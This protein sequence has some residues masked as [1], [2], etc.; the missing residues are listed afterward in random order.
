MGRTKKKN[1]VWH[2]RLAHVRDY[3]VARLARYKLAV[4]ISN[5]N[6][7][8]PTRRGVILLAG[9]LFLCAAGVR[10]A[11]Y[12]AH[13]HSELLTLPILD[14]A[15]YLTWA[16]EIL[17]GIPR[18]LGAFFTEPG[19]AYLMA[20]SLHLFQTWTP[21]IWVQL[22]L[23]STLPVLTFFT[24]R[25]LFANTIVAF[26]AGLLM[27]FFRPG[28]FHDILLLKTSFEL[29]LIATLV[30]WIVY[31]WEKRVWWH[32]LITGLLVGLTALIK[33]NVL[34][35][36]P[37]FALAL[38]FPR[39]DTMRRAAYATLSMC[40]GAVLAISPTTIHNIRTTGEI[41][42]I[43]YSGGVTVYIG[44]WEH[45][46]GSFMVPEYFSL[47]PIH[48]EVSWHA[49]AEALSGESLTASETSSYWLHAGIR[50]A[51]AFPGHFIGVTLK[52][53][54]LLFSGLEIAD[55]YAVSFG[56]M[57]FPL[58]V[59]LVPYWLITLLGIVGLVWYVRREGKHHSY[60]YA[61]LAGYAGLVIISKVAERYRM[62]LAVVLVLFAAYAL[63][64]LVLL[65]KK[66][67][68][69]LEFTF[70]VLL[71][72]LASGV[73][74][75]VHP[76]VVTTEPADMYL[77]FAGAYRDA[78]EFSKALSML[79]AGIALSPLHEP[80][81][82]NKGHI[83][84]LSGDAPGALHMYRTALRAR[85]DGSTR[86]LSLSYPCVTEGCDLTVVQ[87]ALTAML[88]TT[89]SWSYHK[90]YLEGMRALRRGETNVAIAALETAR[91]ERSDIRGVSSN[92]ALLYGQLGDDVKA[93]EYLLTAATEDSFDVVVYYNLGNAYSRQEKYADAIPYYAHVQELV[94]DFNLTRYNLAR[95]YVNTG[96]QWKAREQYLAFIADAEPRGAYPEQVARARQSVGEIEQ[97]MMR[98]LAPK[99]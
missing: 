59:W 78:G 85:H 19:Y 64:H 35:V 39:P 89:P 67:H 69:R 66:K 63:Y 3:V 16:Q 84:L 82:Q 14:A 27:A 21:V 34:Y 55:N 60:I 22:I 5:L 4:T 70:L 76:S 99:K 95:A 48:E 12:F 86:G 46:D 32:F 37:L 51:V 11:F 57:Q 2:Q 56:E 42:P 29:W 38:F 61:F 97:A 71:L 44:N 13:L 50:E 17:A 25:R 79:D 23:G 18:P 87:E 36:A 58:L 45:A 9:L 65:A 68:K 73:L 40:A 91:A 93:Q 54:Y 75:G 52:K 10:V 90:E 74:T 72:V 80:L 41:I 83:L 62:A 81:L 31:T 94:P 26:L 53:I 1:T 49:I 47:D 92:L 15:A 43:N 24:A 98:D 6:D 28:I 8:V 77:S 88:T 20:L 7:V 30:L 96:E 33:A